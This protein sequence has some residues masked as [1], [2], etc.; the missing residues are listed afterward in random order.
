MTSKEF[1]SKESRFREKMLEHVF[2][3]EILQYVWRREQP[4]GILRTEVD[5]AGYDLVLEYEEI[6]RY[7]QLKSSNAKSPK[8]PK[9]S[10]PVVNGK[11]ARKPGGC[12]IWIWLVDEDD[13]NHVKLEYWFLGGTPGECP[14]LGCKKGKRPG[15]LALSNK[16]FK[17]L[18]IAD[19]INR[20]LEIPNPNQSS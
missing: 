14:D 11:L 2:L 15:T 19:L 12:V 18:S 4:V 3:S 10:P 7:I 20:L 5:R 1:D 9:P 13:D 8:K 16:Q 6:T 17:Q